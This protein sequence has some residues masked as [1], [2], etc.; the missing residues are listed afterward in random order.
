MWGSPFQ[1]NISPLDDVVILPVDVNLVD[2]LME[3]Q[4]APAVYR[5][6]LVAVWVGAWH[7]VDLQVQRV[8]VQVLPVQ[9]G[10]PRWC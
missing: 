4:P 6:E 9:C 10:V 1:A 2:I 5:L 3:G 8:Q 7:Q